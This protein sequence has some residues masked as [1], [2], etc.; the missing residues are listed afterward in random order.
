MGVLSE[1]QLSLVC[2]VSNVYIELESLISVCSF[3]APP[4]VP[5]R[6]L[7]EAVLQPAGSPA[8]TGMIPEM[9]WERESAVLS[10]AGR[11]KLPR[12]SEIPWARFAKLWEQIQKVSVL[13]V[14]SVPFCVRFWWKPV[15]TS[16]TFGIYVPQYCT[17]LT[18]HRVGAAKQG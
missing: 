18:P 10:S 5:C 11:K 16:C 12:A 6:R 2:R 7:V 8:F 17:I 15:R 14:H 13:L 4:S 1:K 3:R 9:L